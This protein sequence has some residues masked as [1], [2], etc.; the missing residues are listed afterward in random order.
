MLPIV[1]GRSAAELPI[2]VSAVSDR[3]LGET[4]TPI[5]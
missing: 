1:R 3:M 2:Q 4:P 5:G